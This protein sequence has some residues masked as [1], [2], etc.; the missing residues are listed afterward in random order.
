MEGKRGRVRG[1]QRESN[2]LNLS[3]PNIEV[4]NGMQP[5]QGIWL[6][7]GAKVAS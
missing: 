1:S 7:P 3:N 6:Q 2:Q 4:L 5:C